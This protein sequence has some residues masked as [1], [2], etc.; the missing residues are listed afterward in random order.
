[1]KMILAE[2]A[3]RMMTT[4]TLLD[5]GIEFS[6]ADG[7]KSLIPYADVPEVMN[8]EGISSVELPNPFKLVLQTPRGKFIE[9][10]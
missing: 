8:R 1:M 2:N 4:T 5:D 3:N 6:F 7:F 9:I 10:L